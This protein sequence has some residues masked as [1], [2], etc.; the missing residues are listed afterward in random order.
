VADSVVD[1]DG[2][3]W[4]VRRRWVPRLGQ[5]TVWGRFHRRFRQARERTADV[6]DADP[7][8][9]EAFAEGIVAVLV[10]IAVVVFLVFVGLPALFALLDLVVVLLLAVVGVVARV[11]FRRP[12]TIEATPSAGR[13]LQWRVTGWRASEAHRVQIE[14]HLANGTVD[15]LDGMTGPA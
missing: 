4:V 15:R 14:R 11:L 12:W 10:V 9:F 5:E 8:C 1:P 2:T 13:P 6:A 7:G 3:R